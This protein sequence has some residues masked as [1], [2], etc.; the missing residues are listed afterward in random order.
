[1][2]VKRRASPKRRVSVKRRSPRRVS[3][4]RRS[5]RRASPKRRSPRR[6]SP[7]RRSP[8]RVSVKRRRALQRG[9]SNYGTLTTNFLTMKLPLDKDTTIYGE[10]MSIWK[11]LYNDISVM[12]YMEDYINTTLEKTRDKTFILN[13]QIKVDS[14]AKLQKLNKELKE[15]TTPIVNELKSKHSELQLDLKPFSDYVRGP[16][17]KFMNRAVTS[18]DWILRSNENKLIAQMQ[19][20]NYDKLVGYLKKIA[21]RYNT[22]LDKLHEIFWKYNDKYIDIATESKINC[23]VDQSCK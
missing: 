2:S 1:V 19:N 11:F 12:P 13:K 5:P 7:K 16:E 10:M 15:D 8:R 17:R 9:G 20:G 22:L 14:L 21:P 4:K 23:L 3:V 18:R 6:V